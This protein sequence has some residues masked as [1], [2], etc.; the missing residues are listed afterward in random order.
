G[1]GRGARTDALELERDAA[2][3][4]PP[5]RAVRARRLQAAT[6]RAAALGL[7]PGARPAR[8]RRLRAVDLARLGPRARDCRPRGRPP[9][10]RPRLAPA[11]RALRRGGP[12]LHPAGG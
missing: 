1:G 2:G 4:G 5:R 7:P 11:L 3:R 10:P 6:R 12:L 8:G 9:P